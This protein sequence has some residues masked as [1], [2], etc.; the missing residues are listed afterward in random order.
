MKNRSVKKVLSVA[1]AMTLMVGGL[2]PTSTVSGEEVS[3][4]DGLIISEYVEGGGYNKAIEI[5][6]GTGQQVDLSEFDLQLFSNESS[7]GT[8]VAMSGVVE[9]GAAHTIINNQAAAHFLSVADETSGGINHNGNDRYVLYYNG[10]I[11]DAFGQKGNSSDFAKDV[12]L[13]RKSS[14]TSGDQNF[15]DTFDPAE[16]WISFAKD[17]AE[18][19]GTHEMDGT[20]STGDK[21]EDNEEPVSL[22]SI[23]DVRAGG[24]GQAGVSIEGVVT[25]D[26]GSWGRKGFYLQ[27]DTSGIYVFQDLY[28]DEIQKG[29]IVQITGDTTEYDGV[30]ELV[31]VSNL[32]VQG[33]G[34]L[35]EPQVVSPSGVTEENQGSLIQLKDV[36]ISQVEEVN[37]YG[38]FEFLATKE[39]ES[40][41]VRI[42]N[43]TGLSYAD[44]LYKEGMVLNVTGIS[45]EYNGT[46]QVKP[47]G[48]DDFS[49]VSAGT[50]DSI[51]AMPASGGVQEGS[52]VS[53]SSFGE[54]D[55]YY[56]TDGSEPTINSTKYTQPITITEDTTIKA[57]QVGDEETSSVV[58]FTYQVLKAFDDLR[59]HDIQGETH[60]SLYNGENV[61]GVEGIVTR[62]VG[63]RGFYMQELPGQYDDN[64]KT[65]EGIYVYSTGDAGV[66]VGDRVQVSGEVKEYTQSN[67][68][69]FDFSDDLTLTEITGASVSVEESGVELPE[70]VTLGEQGRVI[71]SEVI[72][73]DQFSVFDPEEDAIDFYESLEGMRVSAP[74]ATV[75]MPRAEYTNYDETAVTVPNGSSKTRT[76]AGGIIVEPSLNPERII[77]DD[78]SQDMAPVK[79]GDTFTS[80]VTGVLGYEFSNFKLEVDGLP[81]VVPGEFERETTTLQQ[82]EEE[83]S[84]ATYNMEN[85]YATDSDHP[86][87]TEEIAQSIVNRLDAPDIVGL[88]EVQDNN[89]ASEGGTDAAE[90]YKALID[91]IAE[92]GGPEYAYTDIAPVNNEDG[93]EPDGNIRVGFIYNPDR[94]SLAEQP[95]G[96]AT[97]S[98][99]VTEEGSL[100]LNPGRIDPTNEA[101]EDSRKPLAA[102]F[103]FNGENVIVVA[104]HFNSKGG[105]DAPFGGIQPAQLGSE[106]QRIEQ[107]KVVNGFVQEVMERD[108][109]ANVVV[110]GDL[111]DFE[112]SAPLETL[113]GD[114]LANMIEELPE[115]ERYTYNYQGNSQTL[116]HIL[117]ADHLK[118]QTKV[119]I[120]HLNADFTEE[121]GRVSDHDP[122][123]IHMDL[124]EPKFHQDWR[125]MKEPVGYVTN[126]GELGTRKQGVAQ[127]TFTDEEGHKDKQ[128]VLIAF[129]DDKNWGKQKG[130]SKGKQKMMEQQ[131]VQILNEKG[132]VV[133]VEVTVS[134][135][136]MIIPSWETVEPGTYSISIKDAQKR[137]SMTFHIQ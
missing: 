52:T 1:S 96:G 60:Q 46:A 87:K 97:T 118:D 89:G 122:V 77:I 27:D 93:G 53:L 109:D 130:K 66:T 57:I 45:S 34:E 18:Y 108:E 76:P 11:V 132:E 50:A 19:L 62:T 32:N 20:D 116:D 131:N 129:G 99:G 135:N 113:E 69:W 6:N 49:F 79:V 81:T 35:P 90:N 80:A 26:V 2:A 29:D 105:D 24:A 102:E 58:T 119:D 44:F 42:D 8:S 63:S 70:P 75:V 101:F 38:T 107:A 65:S 72:D 59:I 14:V 28:S 112:Y 133:P 10:E 85:Y 127:V 4:P 5:F 100:T 136:K 51:Q 78:Y 25:T 68:L 114:I 17:T 91:A 43:R 48:G 12:T 36:T 86:D 137:G 95:K 54:G 47:R 15:E 125:V 84:V 61:S 3:A 124:I 92:N 16:E 71:P 56:T 88:V 40:V 134:G 22:T 121:Q 123:L 110:L 67:F 41:T 23:A 31:N 64:V 33:A 111:N 82:G 117:V 13:V 120:V 115:N 128:T 9:A 83:L 39:G 55:I 103:E 30:F 7:T 37:S 74:D 126:K 73:N 98:V 104:N 94:V 106:E 21:P